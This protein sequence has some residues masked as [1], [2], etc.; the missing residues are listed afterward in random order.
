MDELK[1]NKRLI[2]FWNTFFEPH[3]AAAIKAED[4][5]IENDLDRLL[6][7]VGDHS[8]KIL[9][10]GCGSGYCLLVAK[11]LGTK[12]IEGLG[13]DP[14]KEAIRLLDETIR[15]SGI[16][17]LKT[18][19]GTH[20][21]LASYPDGAFD[22]IVCSNVLDVIPEQT[23]KEAIDTIRRLLKPGGLF[24]LKLNFYLTPALIEKIKMEPI[25]KNTYT[26]NGVIRS[27]NLTTDE[28]I[29]RFSG[30]DVLETAEYERIPNGPK[31]RVIL[32]RRN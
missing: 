19:V 32:F 27:V 17:G 16:E 14:A 1:E 5:T 26:I 7:V 23:S 25:G 11:G 20:H 12:V 10:L 31:D 30:F 6:K 4:Y 3:Q 29:Q 15:L 28:W 13:I 24:L 8:E 18:M 21:D 22:G 2:E 9:D